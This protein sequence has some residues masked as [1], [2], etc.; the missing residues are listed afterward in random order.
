MVLPAK[1]PVYRASGIDSAFKRDADR[2]YDVQWKRSAATESPNGELGFY[3]VGNGTTRA[4]RART[5]PP[6]YV[7]FALF[8]HII[9]GYQLSDVVAVLGSINIIAAELD[10]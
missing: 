9:R 8:P 1:P 7:H 10:R 6:S 5:R 2:G 3:I 4:Y